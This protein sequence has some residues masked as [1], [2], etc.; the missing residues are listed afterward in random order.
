MVVGEDSSALI[1]STAKDGVGKRVA[2]GV[3]VPSAVDKG[4]GVLCSYDGI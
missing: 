2:G 3:D 1:D 4:V